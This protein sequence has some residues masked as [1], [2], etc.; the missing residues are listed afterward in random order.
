[1]SNDKNIFINVIAEMILK[2]KVWILFLSFQS[3][4][5]LK[6]AFWKGQDNIMVIV[7]IKANISWI[8][9]IAYK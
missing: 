6:G 1:M 7:S 9:A 4:E 5:S 8:D 3:S 2:F